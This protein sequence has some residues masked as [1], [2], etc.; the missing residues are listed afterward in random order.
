M[1]AKKT[2]IATAE[3]RI[4]KA[5]IST[6]KRAARKVDADRK[7]EQ[8]RITTEIHKLERLYTKNTNASRTAGKTI[9]R[10]LAILEGRLFS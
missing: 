1:P 7:K 9:L 6:L 8:R 2:T 5:E 3:K 10:R 4:I